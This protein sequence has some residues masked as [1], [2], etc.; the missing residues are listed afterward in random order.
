MEFMKKAKNHRLLSQRK[1]LL[2]GRKEKEKNELRFV[3]FHPTQ[4]SFF[5]MATV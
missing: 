1:T 4:L 2:R 5:Q 3:R